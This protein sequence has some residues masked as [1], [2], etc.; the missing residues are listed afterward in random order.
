MRTSLRLRK[1]P[2]EMR[3]RRARTVSKWNWRSDV[4][5]MRY[6]RLSRTREAPMDRIT[7]SKV[8]GTTT[9]RIDGAL[10]VTGGASYSS[11]QHFEGLL[12]AFPVCATIGNG[13]ITKLDTTAAE[14]MPGVVAVYHRGNIGTFYRVAPSD[15]DG[16][17]IDEKRPPLEDDV[18]RYYGQYVAVVV[19]QTLEQARAAAEQVKVSY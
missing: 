17:R 15:G 18:I 4:S 5:C 8:I 14:K 6:A 13:A 10:K 2:C 12:H 19:A 16:P 9:P 3:N 1:L 7:E 11:D